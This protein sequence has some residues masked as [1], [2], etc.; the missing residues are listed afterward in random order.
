MIRPG[1]LH[2]A[3]L[4]VAD[5]ERSR[6]FYE[7]VLGMQ[8]V[9]RPD[10]GFRG[11]WYGLG[12]GQLH[13]MECRKYG[14]GPI[15]PTE[16]HV[17]IEVED[18][19]AAKATLREHGV[20]FLELGPQLWLHDPDGYTVELRGKAGRR[21]ALRAN[22]E[23]GP[24][25]RPKYWL[26]KTEPATYSFARLRAE[27]RT[28]WDG[29]KNPL[30]LKH[31][32]SVAAGDCIFIYHT[33]EEKAAVGVARAASAPYS[34]P[35]AR[36]PKLLVVDLVPLRALAKPV[37]LAAIKASKRFAGFDLVR[38][39]RLSVMPVSEAQADEIEKMAK[40]RSIR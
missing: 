29:V 14:E 16:A 3:A 1:K 30:A 15:D 26:F 39:P 28:T 20:E 13:L 34:D 38:L 8:T 10:L 7:E 21:P 5:F 35:K 32:A 11:A 22:L 4:R 40:E 6:A 36:D 31:L 12:G 37:S 9:P 27:G 24:K 2:H 25:K 33:G 23:R 17:A 18:Y 19:E